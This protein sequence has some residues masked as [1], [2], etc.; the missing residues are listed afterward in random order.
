MKLNPRWMMF[1]S[2][3][4]ELGLS[5]IVGLVLGSALDRFFG[6]EPW[7][8]IVFSISGIAAGYRSVYRLLKR[9]QREDSDLPTNSS[10]PSS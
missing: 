9:L 3:G 2:M 1:S 8:L 4:L 7:M 6:T 10:E 5:V